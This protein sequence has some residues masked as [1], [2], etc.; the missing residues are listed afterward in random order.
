M[1]G[2]TR[3]HTGYRT[4]L[5]VYFTTVTPPSATVHLRADAQRNRDAVLTAAKEVFGEQGLEAPLN[6]IARR[7]GVGQGTLYRRF[8]T[9]EALIEAIAD[10]NLAALSDLAE[11]TQDRPDAFIELF[12]GA[13]ELQ[14]QNQGFTDM[15]AKSPHAERVLRKRRARFLATVEGPLRR[16]QQA[17]LIRAD[18]TPQDVRLLLYMLGAA[19]RCA[20]QRD[21]HGRALELVLDALKPS[22]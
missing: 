21:G 11:R 9:R 13:V 17:N 15:L 16:S 3:N 12:L 10:D 8:P 18:L 4:R 20:D 7:A 22:P 14:R 5:S 19:N 6:E 2:C 1:S